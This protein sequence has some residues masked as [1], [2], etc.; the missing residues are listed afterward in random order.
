MTEFIVTFLIACYLD[1][2]FVISCLTLFGE[3]D[4]MFEY[5]YQPESTISYFRRIKIAKI[6]RTRMMLST[7]ILPSIILYLRKRN[8]LKN[9]V[10]GFDVIHYQG[11]KCPFFVGIKKEFDTITV[12]RTTLTKLEW[13]D[14]MASGEYIYEIECGYRSDYEKCIKVIKE[15]IVYLEGN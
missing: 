8:Y 5:I 3:F 7:L 15:S 11:T 12:G 13:L 14:Y 1:G 6:K 9:Y 10:T 2:I 4:Y